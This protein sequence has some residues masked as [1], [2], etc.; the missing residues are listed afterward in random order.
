[1]STLKPTGKP[2]LCLDFDG[3]IHSYTSGWQGADVISD[4]PVPGAIEFLEAALEHFD[5][6]ILSSRSHQSG[7]IGAMHGWLAQWTAQMVNGR[8][9][10]PEWVFQIRLVTE[11][12]PAHVTIDDRGWAF[13]GEWPSFEELKVFKPWNRQ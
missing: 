12:P 13:K 4:E 6:C 2:I 3:V 8:P 11:K 10:I 9:W 1:M 7:G 5:V